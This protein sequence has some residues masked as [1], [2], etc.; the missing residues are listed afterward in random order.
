[1]CDQ[2]QQQSYLAL[3][4]CMTY[5]SSCS[6]KSDANAIFFG[7]C[8]YVYYSNIVDH[9]YLAL[10]RNVSDLNDVFCAPQNRDGLLCRDCIDG[11]G[12]SVAT[13]GYAC[14]NCT[15]IS[16]GWMLYIL[17]EFV[18]ATMFLGLSTFILIVQPYKKN[19][20][21]V[22][23]GLL[24]GL[25]GFLSLLLITFQYLLPSRN[26]TLPLIYV[27][28]C[29]LPQ[30]ALLLS[31]TYRHV[32][33]KWIAQYVAGRVGALLKCIHTGKQTEGAQEDPLPHR[34]VSPDQYNRPLLS[35]SEQANANVTSAVQGPI[36]PV[37]TY[38]SIN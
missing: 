5:N 27:I 11:F 4:H 22:L 2:V 18:P 7:A 19:Y 32:K 16:Y 9:R 35:V 6:D 38:R 13:F 12:P 28:T 15:E 26:E 34:I 1:M 3:G 21:N 23:D 37:Y 8:P 31:I 29:S 17:V 33:G 24:L 14:A 10:P 25:L 30:L 36:P 20:M